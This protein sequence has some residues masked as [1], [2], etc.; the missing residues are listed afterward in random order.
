[1]GGASACCVQSTMEPAYSLTPGRPATSDRPN[2]SVAAQ[3]PVL[4]KATMSWPCSRLTL[5]AICLAVAVSTKV[6]VPGTNHWLKS[7]CCAPGRVPEILAAGARVLPWRS[8]EHT[9]DPVTL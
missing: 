2:Q 6:E 1:M 5:A 4:Q 8:E 7:S 9:S 3:W